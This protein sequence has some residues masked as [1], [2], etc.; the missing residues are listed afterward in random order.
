MAN[1]SIDP[2]KKTEM[3]AVV[4]RAKSAHIRWRAY[5]QG[6]VSGVPITEDQAPTVHTE[7]R[8]GKWYYAEGKETFGHLQIFDDIAV[9]HEML[10]SVYQQIFELVNNGQVEQAKD[11]LDELMEISRTL[12]EQIE[13]LE[14]EIEAIA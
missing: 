3:L 10:H 1:T 11:R 2:K 4:R 9:P 14:K 5:A 13:L 8:F 6:L 7:C 12:L